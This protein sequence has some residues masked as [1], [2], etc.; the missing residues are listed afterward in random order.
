MRLLHI[1]SCLWL[2]L[3]SHVTCAAVLAYGPIVSAYYFL[4]CLEFFVF[5]VIAIVPISTLGLFPG[6]CNMGARRNW[7]CQAM[8][9]WLLAADS[10]LAYP[11]PTETASTTSLKT[12]YPPVPT[13]GRLFL[14]SPSAVSWPA[15]INGTKI[16][17][18]CSSIQLALSTTSVESQLEVLRTSGWTRG[19]TGSLTTTRKLQGHLRRQPRQQ[20]QHQLPRET[21]RLRLLRRRQIA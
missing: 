3:L 15:L 8:L 11:K 12:Q 9:M 5:F 20:P 16:N 18:V 1:C 7:G 13:N 2:F 10:A 4:Y 14:P 6:D 21:P 19:L 17:M